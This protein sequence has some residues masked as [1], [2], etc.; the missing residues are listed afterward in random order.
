MIKTISNFKYYVVLVLNRYRCVQY[1]AAAVGP[2]QKLE[3]NCCL[4]LVIISSDEAFAIQ[5]LY[6]YYSL[7]GTD[8]AYRHLNQTF[9]KANAG[10]ETSNGSIEIRYH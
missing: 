6:H 1:F 8:H 3:K 2:V 9:H 5:P 7:H 10:I 4:W